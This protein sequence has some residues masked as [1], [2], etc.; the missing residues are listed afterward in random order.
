[1]RRNRDELTAIGSHIRHHL[2]NPEYARLD[3]SESRLSQLRGQLSGETD[4]LRKSHLE[5]EIRLIELALAVDGATPES[6]D[7][8][9]VRKLVVGALSSPKLLWRDSFGD[10][11]E[12]DLLEIR[13]IFS[14]EEV[15]TARAYETDDPLELL[16]VGVEPQETCQSWRSGSYNE[17][18][19]SYVADGNKKV[20]NVRDGKGELVARSV[21]KLT[22]QKEVDDHEGATERPT[23]L[24]E[25]PYGPSLNDVILRAYARLLFSKAESMG[26]ISVTLGSEFDENKMKILTEEAAKLGYA[27]SESRN[28]EVYIPRSANKYEY[29]D[30]LGGAV[31]YF[32]T[33]HQTKT[34]TFEKAAT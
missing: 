26:G 34:V 20:L 17:C 14:L 25:N 23:I 8:G 33:Y 29:S 16:K 31:S 11:V 2:S 19:L 10:E 22:K 3:L 12:R 13:K 7:R 32:D 6:Y 1:L 28:L 21:I 4:K 30:A 15:E 9:S 18:L 24:V 27:P 5:A